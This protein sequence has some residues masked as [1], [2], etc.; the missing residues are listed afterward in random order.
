MIKITATVES[1]DQA[2][3]LID[4][5]VDVIYVGND[6]YGLR[7]PNS[8]NL[9]EI[10][11]L[12]ELAHNN[13]KQIVVAVNGIM[14][15][16]KME[17]LPKYFKDLE[18]IGVDF[19]EIGDTGVLYLL[20][21]KEINIPFIFNNQMLMTNAKQINFWGK[22]GAV[23]TVLGREVPFAE[24]KELSKGIQSP[25]FAEVLVYGATCIHQSLRPLVT[26]YY[27]FITPKDND[28][29]KDRGLFIS[30]PEDDSTHYSIFEDE[31]GTHIFA[32]NDLNLMNE[33]S[34]LTEFNYNHWKLDGI[35][36]NGD[37]FV[38]ITKLFIQAKELILTNQFTED[39]A[40]KL[41]KEVMKYH[42][43][44][45]GLDTGFFYYSPDDVR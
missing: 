18:E 22:K 21:E 3:K 42:P 24:M 26:N 5:G 17:L 13:N 12:T 35:Y 7:L 23:G 15:K 10:R 6:K 16:D 8:F 28:T 11:E 25:L 33:L 14:H 45:R 44:E 32:N 36:C 43:E 1:I 31:H 41:S 19:I 9:Q 40:K 37:K 27:N 4:A 20:Q 29:S 2:Q 34:K 30:E 38:E 39:I